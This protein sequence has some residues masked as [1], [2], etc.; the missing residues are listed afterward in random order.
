MRSSSPEPYNEIVNV[1]EQAFRLRRVEAMPRAVGQLREWRHAIR[2]LDK[3]REGV[4]AMAVKAA[5]D[6]LQAMIE[7]NVGKY[8]PK[9][10]DGP[11]PEQ[12]RQPI[13]RDSIKSLEDA[14]RITPEQARAARDIQR[15]IEI[16]TTGSKP[17]CQTYQKGAVGFRPTGFMTAETAVRWSM[18][19]VPWHNA[20]SRRRDKRVKKLAEKVIVDGWSLDAARKHLRMSYERGHEFL[21]DALDLYIEIKKNQDDREFPVSTMSPAPVSSSAH[22]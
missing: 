12:A 9:D 3:R 20:L 18:I 11:T 5:C 7:K 14:N 19:Y 1:I 4:E 10:G 21:V 13:A 22:P 16:I 17:K 2:V 15:I 6:A 8:I